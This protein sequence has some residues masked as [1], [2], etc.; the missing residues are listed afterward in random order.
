MNDSEEIWDYTDIFT[1]KPL[2]STGAEYLLSNSV[3]VI[4]NEK[5]NS[6]ILAEKVIRKLK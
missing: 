4:E 5:F 1:D 6:E 2:L 3:Q